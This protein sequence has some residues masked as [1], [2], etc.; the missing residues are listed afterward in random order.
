M[1]GPAIGP[2]IV[3]RDCRAR[4]HRAYDNAIAGDIEPGDMRRGAES[5]GDL[6]GIAIVELGRNVAGDAVVQLGRARGCR[7]AR[8]GH[9]RQGIDIEQDGFGG[10][11]CLGFGNDNGDRIADVADLVAGQRRTGRPMHRAAVARRDR[12]AERHR[13]DAGGG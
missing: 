11:F 12:H 4:L 5:A 13:L 6:F 1:Q 3:I 2:G 8:A 10:V 7:L 9:G